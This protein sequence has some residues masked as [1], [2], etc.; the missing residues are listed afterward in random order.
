[1][2]NH[3]VHECSENVK[4]DHC[5]ALWA[6]VAKMLEENLQIGIYVGILVVHSANFSWGHL[7][8]RSTYPTFCFC[9]LVRVVRSL[10]TYAR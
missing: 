7:Q 3:A 5:T 4:R 9:A 6:S 8:I 10:H 2:G 1:M